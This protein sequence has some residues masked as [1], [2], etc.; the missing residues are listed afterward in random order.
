MLLNTPTISILQNSFTT[1]S[2]LFGSSSVSPS[3]SDMQARKEQMKQQISQE[4]AIANAQQLINVS[5]RTGIIAFVSV[6]G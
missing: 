6:G 3:G 4:L 2:S 1:M 5:R